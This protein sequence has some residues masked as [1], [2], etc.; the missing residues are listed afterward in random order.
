MDAEPRIEDAPLDEATRFAESRAAKTCSLIVFALVMLYTLLVLNVF[1]GQVPYFKS[2]FMEMGTDLPGLTIIV[3]S[4]APTAVP[5]VFLAAIGS[6]VKEFAV[7]NRQTTLV[8]NGVHFVALVAMKELL[9][10]AL[11]QPLIRLME[12][13]GQ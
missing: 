6:A 7:T 2:M 4:T 1:L 10:V 11:M 8:I 5:L 9:V 12:T 3:L 13:L